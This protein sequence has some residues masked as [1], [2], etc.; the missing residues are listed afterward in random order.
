MQYLQLIVLKYCVNL[1]QRLSSGTMSLLGS[2]AAWVRNTMSSLVADEEKKELKRKLEATQ[3]DL[4]TTQDQLGALAAAAS[5]FT[6][7]VESEHKRSRRWIDRIDLD[8]QAGMVTGLI[9]SPT[10][11][12]D[13]MSNVHKARVVFDHN[14]DG[15][16][17]IPMID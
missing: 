12:Q 4:A 15:Y 17:G 8:L 11:V 10:E 9:L 2:A 5:D 3:K 7:V 1:W 13:L 6:D 16:E 14:D